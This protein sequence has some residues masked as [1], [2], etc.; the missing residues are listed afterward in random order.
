M[1]K[2]NEMANVSCN[3]SKPVCEPVKVPPA[4]LQ[5]LSSWFLLTCTHE[6]KG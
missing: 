2:I 4:A 3:I 6:L 5:A 1:I